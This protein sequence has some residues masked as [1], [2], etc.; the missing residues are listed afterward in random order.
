MQIEGSHQG[1]GQFRKGVI[2][3]IV[4]SLIMFFLL[5]PL[6]RLLWHGI[7]LLSSRIAVSY[8]DM[9]YKSAALGHR[10][11]VS[12][13]LLTIALSGLLGITVGLSAGITRRMFQSKA[14]K[15]MSPRLIVV[16]LW[17]IAGIMTIS[18]LIAIVPTV[19]DLQLNTS[20]QQQ[21]KVISPRVTDQTIKELEASWAMMETRKDYEAIQDSI[22]K[23]ATKN[24]I[25]L[26]KPLIK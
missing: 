7:S 5:E 15:P 17:C 20:F 21:I 23:I 19:I 25:R 9:A 6:A 24:N 11:D 18:S 16:A 14:A 26:P 3:S 1:G 12:V 10:N 8:I 22:L 2:S 4:A 13:L